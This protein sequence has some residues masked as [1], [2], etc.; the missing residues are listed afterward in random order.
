MSTPYKKK[1]GDLN[2]PVETPNS[3][4]EM[5]LKYPPMTPLRGEDFPEY[6]PAKKWKSKLRSIGSS[7]NGRGGNQGTL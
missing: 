4:Y 2:Q 1:Q 3:D 7:N 5:A 6:R